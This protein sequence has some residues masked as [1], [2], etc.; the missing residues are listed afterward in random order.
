MNRNG[1]FALAFH[2]LFVAFIL[3]PILIVCVVAFTP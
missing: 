2:A 3:A 1:P